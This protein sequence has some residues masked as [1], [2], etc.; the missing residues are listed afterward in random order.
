[1]LQYVESKE[2]HD[3]SKDI[4]HKFI[5]RIFDEAGDSIKVATQVSDEFQYACLNHNIITLT[6]IS[7]F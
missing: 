2:D 1:M 7:Y 6:P 4:A 3:R 5:G